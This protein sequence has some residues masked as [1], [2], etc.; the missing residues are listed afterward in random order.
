[1]KAM[2]IISATASAS[3]T[4]PNP[5]DQRRSYQQQQQSPT[6]AIDDFAQHVL[7]RRAAGDVSVDSSLG[8]YV[9]SLLRC[10]SE[11][12]LTD[13]TRM[14]EYEGLVELLQEHCC[15]DTPQ[16]RDALEEIAR[17]VR[18]G[19]VP[20][21]RGFLSP[22]GLY[23][24]GGFHS[25]H[26]MGSALPDVAGADGPESTTDFDEF[27]P[28]GKTATV[29]SPIHA[30]NLIPI[31]LL[32]ELDDPDDGNVPDASE[33]D[34]IRQ[35]NFPPLAPTEP[36]PS[37]KKG[38]QGTKKGKHKSSNLTA[39]FFRATSRSRQSSI[40]ET[41]SHHTTT[42]PMYPQQHHYSPTLSASSPPLSST[43]AIHGNES[44]QYYTH[45]Q[46]LSATEILLSMNPEVDEE[47]AGAAATLA[48]AD[49]NVAQYVVEQALTAP[50]VCRH[51]LQ[52][53]CYRADCTFSHDI[54]GHTCVFWLRGR[55]GKGDSC[56]FKHGFDEK[57]LDR[58]AEW[59]HTQYDSA[60]HQNF[61]VAEEYPEMSSSGWQER[62]TPEQSTASSFA[63][64]ASQGYR[65]S[66]F[67]Q[68][69]TGG[70]LTSGIAELSPV[71]Y[72]QLATVRI[73]QD[74]WNPHENRDSA[75]FFLPDPMERYRKVSATTRREDV[76]DLHFQST[77]TFPIV[78]ETVLPNT[79]K[80][81]GE[82]WVVTGTGHHVG[83]KTH[84]RGGGALEKAVTDWLVEEGYKIARGKD[85]N[86]EG[87][88]VLVKQ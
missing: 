70:A 2:H 17:A 31:D 69:T 53:G 44:A 84:Q 18:S 52:D 78:L 28:L 42:P 77:K 74:L 59:S 76:I 26:T 35:E 8:S 20:K 58:L 75:V 6:E 33:S 87:G 56:R 12:D 24:S 81:Y 5:A 72:Q 50:P 83:M 62:A 19:S 48:H 80:R 85:R 55:C 57:V 9:T 38:K 73:P 36:P 68:Q 23:A 21:G 30:D 27:P 3:T 13:I 54:E 51:L 43:I 39:D 67:A 40:D 10:A 11:T 29:T 4:Y 15:M 49:V 71:Q 16:A 65:P 61:S 82:V 45:Q 46:W 32:G 79:L 25:M 60:Y 66:A 88:A 86:G 34:R 22:G 14:D 41:A 37:H 7:T 64:I 1:M 63:N 47:A